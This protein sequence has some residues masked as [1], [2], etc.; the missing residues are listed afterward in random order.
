M[1]E[2]KFYQNTGALGT[3]QNWHLEKHVGCKAEDQKKQASLQQ[4]QETIFH[5][6]KNCIKSAAAAVPQRPHQDTK[7]ASS[8]QSKR[9][10]R[11]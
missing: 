6:Q 7:D 3:S 11:E 8:N 2:L 5:V 1:K 10:L 4:D 9:K